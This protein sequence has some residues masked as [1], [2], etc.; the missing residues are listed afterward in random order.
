MLTEG[1]TTSYPFSGSCLMASRASFSQVIS[2]SPI[3]FWTNVVVESRA[4]GPRIG[5]FL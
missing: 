4:P 1:V 3:S 5:A 2:T